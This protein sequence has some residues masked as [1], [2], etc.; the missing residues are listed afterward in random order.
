MCRMCLRVPTSNDRQL[1]PFEGAP[2]SWSLGSLRVPGQCHCHWWLEAPSPSERAALAGSGWGMRG[3]GINCAAPGPRAAVVM[4]A[5][6][7]LRAIAPAQA[8]ARP[9]RSAGRAPPS[10]HSIIGTVPLASPR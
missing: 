1:G 5:A 8:R 9:R 2:A 7:S 3:V 4:V 6:P 10:Y